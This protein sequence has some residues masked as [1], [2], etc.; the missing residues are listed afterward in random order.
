MSCRLGDPGMSKCV[1]PSCP[2]YGKS[3]KTEEEQAAK[4]LCMSCM[5]GDP[6]IGKCTN[7]SCRNY[8]NAP[9]DAK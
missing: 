3:N 2:N 7:K 1:Q 5:L 6:S 9:K 4:K 8:G